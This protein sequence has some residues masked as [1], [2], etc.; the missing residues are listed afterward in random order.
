MSMKRS[1]YRS[2]SILIILI[3][4]VGTIFFNYESVLAE[5]GD[6]TTPPSFAEGYPK[7]GNPHRVGSKR[8]SLAIRVANLDEGEEVTAHYFI[9]DHDAT[10]PTTNEVINK[11][12]NDGTIPLRSGQRKVGK[13]GINDSTIGAL[14]EDD[15]DYDAYVVLVDDAGNASEPAMVTLKTPQKLLADGYPKIG[16]PKT[17]GS[18]KVEIIVKGN[19]HPDGLIDDYDF[20]AYYVVVKDGDTQPARFSIVGI[21]DWDP[22]YTVLDSGNIKLESDTEKSFVT[23]S[24]GADSTEYDI[25][26]VL[27][28]QGNWDIWSEVVK[29]DITTPAPYEPVTDGACEIDGIQYATLDDAL[30]T[31]ETGGSADIRLLKNIDYNGSIFLDSKR[32]KI[33]TNGFNL[34]I[35][36]NSGPGVEV[37]DGFLIIED[38]SGG[39]INVTGLHPGVRAYDNSIVSVTNT[40]AT[41]GYGAYAS[42]NSEIYI[43]ENAK[44]SG[45]GNSLGVYA[46]SGGNIIVDGNVEGAQAVYAYGTSTRVEIKGNVTASSSSIDDAA[47]WAWVN[48]EVEVLCDVISKN[49]KFADV[50]YGGTIRIDGEITSNMNIVNVGGKTKNRLNEMTQPT[51]LPGYDTYS[52]RDSFIWVKRNVPGEDWEKPLWPGDS[53]LTA[54][55]TSTRLMVYWPKA[56]DNIGVD[57]YNVYI[58]LYTGDDALIMEL[59]GEVDGE[60]TEPK[61]EIVN[62]QPDTRYVVQVEAV[63]K[64][65][66]IS[67]PLVRTFDTLKRYTIT[68]HSQGGSKI[69]EQIIDENE[70][71][72]ETK[73]EIPEKDGFVFR[74]WYKEADCI[75]PWN[76]ED[77][78]TGDITLY[79]K[80]EMEDDNEQ[81]APVKEEDSDKD[82]LP[83]TGEISSFIYFIAGLVL[84]GLG[85]IIRRKRLA[86]KNT[87]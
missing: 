67:D 22:D 55:N 15:T 44:G 2:L 65:G 33:H 18:Q 9:V 81:E 50:N 71:L 12:Y 7:A 13:N 17:K 82:E 83:K 25:Y 39:E 76:F 74:G 77:I 20:T 46:E 27:S 19:P 32:V 72:D 23:S 52:E 64:A 60:E 45:G 66:N 4:M 61:F 78:V 87:Q 38:N 80:W 75:N 3:L 11:K 57:H 14:P 34:T 24:L 84:I 8:V 10:P 1:T 21:Q 42:N 69:S 58:G 54:T 85:I 16:N 73:L 6:D 62:L 35:T 53:K 29:L 68:F 43:K 40:T 51:T 26:V 79:A 59:I 47:I 5:N 37:R 70:K 28:R 49:C 31:I 48:A 41:N 30:G 63:D 56:E 36:N 86:L